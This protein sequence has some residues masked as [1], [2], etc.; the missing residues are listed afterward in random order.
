MRKVFFLFAIL[1]VSCFA[2]TMLTPTVIGSG[3]GYGSN[4]GTTL[5]YSV[6]EPATA[7]LQGSNG[8]YLTEGFEQ[9]ITVGNTTLSFTIEPTNE[10]CLNNND[11]SAILV[12]NGGTPPFTIVWSSDTTLNSADISGLKPGSY[13]VKVTDK[14]GLT[15]SDTFSIKGSEAPCKIV[16]YTG[17]TPNGDGHNDFWQIDNI[18]L[19]PNNEAIIYN[20]WGTEVWKGN[21]YNNSSV[22]WRGQDMQDKPLPDGTY[23]YSLTVDGYLYKGWVQLT[24]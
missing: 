23:F 13:S 17:L 14:A 22:V 10:S 8:N 20:R 7:T 12:L 4:G 1:P 2:Q 19:F 9:P 21:G 3:G 6:G 11:G 5:S 18:D 15:L 16:I 24:R